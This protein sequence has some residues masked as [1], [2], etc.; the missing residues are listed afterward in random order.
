[1]TSISAVLAAVW[2]TSCSVSDVNKDAHEP[3]RGRVSAA[4]ATGSSER[5]ITPAKEARALHPAAL[6]RR[7]ALS[8]GTQRRS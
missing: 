2:T 6:P 3:E 4:R 5:V 7:D 1:M 8:P